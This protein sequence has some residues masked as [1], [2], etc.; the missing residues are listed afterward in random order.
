M[1]ISNNSVEIDKNVLE[2]LQNISNNSYSN[3]SNISNSSHHTDNNKDDSSDLEPYIW[4]MEI[5]YSRL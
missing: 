1:A 5:M 3:M 2:L 4:L